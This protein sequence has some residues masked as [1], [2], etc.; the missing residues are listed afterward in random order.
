MR[1]VVVLALF[2]AGI[3]A[4]FAIPAAASRRGTNGKLVY[5]TFTVV[6]D[7][8]QAYMIVATMQPYAVSTRGATSR[9][10]RPP[11]ARST[12]GARVSTAPS[13]IGSFAGTSWPA[14]TGGST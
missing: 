6:T 3:A 2:A 14:V 7:R 13:T 12:D 4:M 9:F 5:N 11:A 8:P 1:K 10:P